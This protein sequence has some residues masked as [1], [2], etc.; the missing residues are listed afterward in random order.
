[1][2]QLLKGDKG[3][4]SDNAKKKTPNQRGPKQAMTQITWE[5]TKMNWVIILAKGVIGVDI[6]PLDWS[7]DADGMAT[8]VRRLEERLRDMLGADARLPRVLMSDRGTGM[9]APSGHVTA[10]HDRAVRDCGFK[11]FWG[12]DAKT[13]SPDMPDLLLHETAVSWLRGVLRRTKP[14]VVPWMETPQQ[15][16]RRMMNALDECNR[17]KDVEGLCLQFPGRVEEC[18]A[19]EGARLD[20]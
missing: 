19:E 14:D 5:G 20:Y 4:M 6:L 10:A 17:S 16:S 18:L 12:P 11:L 1:M 15:W 2:K 7:L 8:V 9:Y 13:Q 3:W